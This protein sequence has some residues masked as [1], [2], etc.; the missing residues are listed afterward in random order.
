MSEKKK[1][2]F[3]ELCIQR[4]VLA[5]V[6]SALI[7]VLGLRAMV[8][9][10]IQQFP[11][12]LSSV[13]Q[14]S[15]VYTG[16]DPE[17]VAAFITTP[18]ENAAAQ[19][20]GIDYMTSSSSQ[21]VST[22]NA[23]ID[24]NYDPDKALTEIS[25]Q[26]STVLSQLPE[27]TQQPGISITVG[28]TIDPMYIGFYSDILSSPQ[29]NDYVLRVAQPQ[30]Q[31]VQGVQQ[32]KI[33]GDF[34]IALR[35]WLDPIKLAGYGLTPA[36]VASKLTAN[37][38]VSGIGRS[39]GQANVLNFT[40]NTNL[41][42]IEGFKKLIVK[43]TNE[44]VIRLEDV[45]KVTL[46]PENY[47]TSITFN[48]D[49]A[50][51]I[52]VVV[53]PGANLLQV[54][55]N[56]KKVFAD[57][58]SKLPTGLK[59]KIVYDISNFVHE[60][61]K[62]VIKTLIEAFIIVTIVIL[63]FLASF[64]S[65]IIPVIAIPLSIIGTFFVMYA[66]NYSLNLL[67]LLSLVLAIGLVV[68]DAIIVVENVHR[69]LE[70]G[71]HPI[72][73]S[74]MSAKELTKPIVAITVVLIA[75]YLP[76]GFSEGLSGALFTE[77]AFTLAAA[78]TVSAVIALT[79]SPMM[80]SKM[81]KPIVK[82]QMPKIEEV[83]E[84]FFERLTQGYNKILKYTL[85]VVPVI[86]CFAIIVLASNYFL[87]VNSQ[88]ELSPQ[89]DQ[90]VILS[91]I[92]TNANSSL[93]VT[94]QANQTAGK[95]YSKHS[96]VVN[97]FQVNGTSGSISAPMLN[98]AFGGVNL[99]PWSE[100]KLTSNQ[101]QP[102][103]QK[104]V[105]KIPAGKFAMFQPP[106]LP[107]GGS[108]LPIQVVIETTDPFLA[109][110]QVSQGV[111][112][113]ARA[114]GLFAYLDSDLKYDEA[115][116]R[117]EVNRN[118]VAEMGLT[119]QDVGN[120]L[121]AA[122]SENY[123]NYFDFMGR[124]YQVIP[125]MQRPFRLN[126]VDLLDYYVNVPT[127]NEMISLATVAKIKRIVVP[128]AINH[129]QQ[130]NSATI[131]A[132]AAPGVDTGTALSTLSKIAKEN[133]PKSYIINYA[134][135]SR[136]M[137]QEGSSL[138]VTFGFALIIIYLVLSVLFNSFRDP[139]IIL[140]TVPLAIC[141]AMIFISLG[142]GGTNLNIYTEVGLITLIGLISKHGILIVEFAN[143]E[144][145]AGKSKREA[146]EAGATIRFR[147]IL[148]TSVAMVAGVI[149]LV[150]ATGAGAVSRFNIGIV[151]ATGISIG[152]IFTLFVVPA[153]YLLISKNDP[154]PNDKKALAED[155]QK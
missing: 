74:I 130:L 55:N 88:S 57:I 37:N 94:G 39:D 65:L 40:I 6:I 76:V 83:L 8:T 95:I 141:G 104:E 23:N 7:F 138:L 15:T 9:L 46:G 86:L 101:L 47:N 120:S 81:L 102:I 17:T 112:K 33:L 140:V 58:K 155:K 107:G 150:Y 67:T 49:P 123:L 50:I 82:G 14:I 70:D 61:I 20:N 75:V 56:I 10:P 147:P 18:L 11:T 2:N 131:S 117:V 44:A 43:S 134:A 149:P 113:K 69:H 90:G 26:V 38:A 48:N 53:A 153:M 89:E 22:I 19:V 34:Q 35:A 13:I 77:F 73:A 129:F 100:R 92:T 66:L 64:R 31:A 126:T 135:Q 32:A 121:A 84:N 28:Q 41:T 115:Q 79:L 124:S 12:I 111:I 78:V 109:L 21:N 114:T 72:K 25:A 99:K 71:V 68:D 152:T 16:A 29:V 80:C 30:I 97:S 103:F 4:P 52:G 51:Y 133:S 142:V 60:S 3:T 139:V 145:K 128:E 122:L 110:N 118:M 154:K 96:E 59:A 91:Q 27:E 98:N 105:N 125:Q 62:E 87:F 36:D 143:D 136:Q 132:I 1:I 146:I 151:I 24:L 45:A 63:I 85:N 108:G 127:T 148:M 144:R 116:A 119:M 42:D 54:A 5:I 137:I 106:S 93:G